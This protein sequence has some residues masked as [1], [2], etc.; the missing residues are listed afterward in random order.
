MPSGHLRR[1]GPISKLRQP[2]LA[3]CMPCQLLGAWLPQ[4]PSWLV[5]KSH[6]ALVAAMSRWQLHLGQLQ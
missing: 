1:C 6:K 5:L 2:D 4:S 3:G